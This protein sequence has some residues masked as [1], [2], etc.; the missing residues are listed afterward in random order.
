MLITIALTIRDKETWEWNIEGT[1]FQCLAMQKE[2]FEKLSYSL[3]S[4]L[5]NQVG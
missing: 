2:L 4:V 5:K 3:F 1:Q